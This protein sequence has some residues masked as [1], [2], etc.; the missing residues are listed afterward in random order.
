[1]SPDGTDSGGGLYAR[2]PYSVK[3]GL[4][5]I[6]IVYAVAVLT[7]SIK[8]LIPQD[9]MAVVWFLVAAGLLVRAV[10]LSRQS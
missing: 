1:V 7:D 6:G 5:L 9:V 10:R 2:L 3:L 8:L 4:A